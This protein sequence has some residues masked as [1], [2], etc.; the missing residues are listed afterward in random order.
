VY[1]YVRGGARAGE[2]GGWTQGAKNG[3]AS[4]FIC[5]FRACG[6]AL[7]LT[8]VAQGPNW[9]L[10]W[11]VPKNEVKYQ[12]TTHLNMHPQ[13]VQSSFDAQT[14]EWEPEKHRWDLKL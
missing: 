4:R 2:G 7:V 5:T 8:V 14:T 11:L 13:G 12:A 9:F 3:L 10:N 6:C 1:V